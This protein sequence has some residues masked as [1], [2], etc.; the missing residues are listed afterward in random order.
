MDTLTRSSFFFSNVFLSGL[1]LITFI[2]AI[3]TPSQK[4]RNILNLETTVSCVAALFYTYFIQKIDDG[5]MTLEKVTPYRYLDW[6]ITTPMLLLVLMIFFKTPVHLN[7]FLSA[8][9]L[10]FGMLFS[11][12]MGETGHIPRVKGSLFGF[13]FFAGLLGLILSTYGSTMT[14]IQWLM[15]IAFAVVWTMYGVVYWLDEK[16]KNIAYNSLDVIAK[17]FFGLFIW[18]YYANIFD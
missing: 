14:H 10:N 13:G 17:V 12:Y 3:R 4:L 6:T 18:V 15:F 1:T 2:E 9:V 8:A 16:K 11:G 7:T 5:T